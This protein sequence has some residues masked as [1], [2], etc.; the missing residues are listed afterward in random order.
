MD[1]LSRIKKSKSFKCC[2]FG[3]E[4]NFFK[5]YFFSALNLAKD[6]AS[7]NR[8]ELVHMIRPYTVQQSKNDYKRTPILSY[9]TWLSGISGYTNIE[10]INPYL[11]DEAY[12]ALENDQQTEEK[13]D[14]SLKTQHILD[15]DGFMIVYDSR[16]PDSLDKSKKYLNQI[17]TIKGY[18]KLLETMK[19]D[20][21]CFFPITLIGI[22]KQL[23]EKHQIKFEGI[24]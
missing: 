23:C 15:A 12:K 8:Y 24:S 5:K 16:Y 10:F 18:D 6:Y 17:F 4:N 9:K 22:N 13:K 1:V 21:M 2:V 20:H 3:P 14:I 11:V 19:H 7:L